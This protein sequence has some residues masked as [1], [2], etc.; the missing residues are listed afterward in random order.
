MLG[1]IGR[2]TLLHEQFLIAFHSKSDGPAVPVLGGGGELFAAPLRKNSAP[3]IFPTQRW[4]L[5][6]GLGPGCSVWR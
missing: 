3:T 4:M 5:S 1:T 6:V 2:D